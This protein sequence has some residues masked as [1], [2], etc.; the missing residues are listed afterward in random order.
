[1]YANA[2][3]GD[4]VAFP[5]HIGTQYYWVFLRHNNGKSSIQLTVGENIVITCF[6]SIVTAWY[7]LE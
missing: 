3:N 2:K 4:N 7:W 1:M 5:N 6:G